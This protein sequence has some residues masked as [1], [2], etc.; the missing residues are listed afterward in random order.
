MSYITSLLVHILKPWHSR[1]KKQQKLFKFF[2]VGMWNSL[3]G[4]GVFYLLDTLFS[5]I[6]TAR[7]MAYM[8]AL[9]LAQIFGI[10]NAY[11]SHKQITFESSAKGRHMIREFMRFF[12]TYAVVFCLNSLFMPVLVEIFH[13]VPKISGLLLMLVM[14]MVSWIGHSRFS[15]NRK[16]L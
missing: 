10:I 16:T 4:F 5:Q 9:S 2:F 8:S 11:I 13:I 6:F 7:Y 3:F 14:A 1:N 15:F 12:M